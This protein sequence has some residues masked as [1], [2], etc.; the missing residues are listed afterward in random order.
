MKDPPN[1]FRSVLVATWTG[2]EWKDDGAQLDGIEVANAA[3]LDDGTL[4]VLLANDG[5]GREGQGGR[6]PSPAGELNRRR[7]DGSWDRLVFP[8]RDVPNWNCLRFAPQDMGVS[9]DGGVW[10]TGRWFYT[11]NPTPTTI[12]FYAYGALFRLGA[13]KDAE[14]IEIE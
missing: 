5:S 12:D 8:C 1:T 14:V 7:P 9:S 3:L 6:G 13:A 4:Y 2:T 11:R 10:V